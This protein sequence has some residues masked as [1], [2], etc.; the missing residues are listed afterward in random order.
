MSCSAP[1]S[2]AAQLDVVRLIS[3]FIFSRA[4]L[5]FN[6]YQ[7]TIV[8]ANSN[9]KA[10]IILLSAF[11]ELTFPTGKNSLSMGQKY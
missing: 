6:S 3:V 10:L 5:L 2:A 7:T 1:L 8:Y 4:S 11:I 9:A